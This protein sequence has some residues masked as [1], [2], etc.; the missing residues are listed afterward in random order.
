MV[1][2]YSPGVDDPRAGL[3][4]RRSPP[5]LRSKAHRSA[6]PRSDLRLLQFRQHR[7]LHIFPSCFT[8]VGVF[9]PAIVLRLRS[10]VMPVGFHARFMWRLPFRISPRS[11][12]V[13]VS[14]GRVARPVGL[15]PSDIRACFCVGGR[16][17]VRIA[18]SSLSYWWF[19][20]LGMLS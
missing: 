4:K 18:E 1:L 9:T 19:A 11:F 7:V 15:L 2:L 5:R 13:R 12:L 16:R 6:R 8:F 14:R 20:A 3:R 10:P 17:S